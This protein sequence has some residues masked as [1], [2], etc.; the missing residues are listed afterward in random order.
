MN[1]QTIITL[2]TKRLKWTQEQL[3]GYLGIDRATVSRIEN[4]KLP[5]SGPVAKLLNQ[6][7]AEAPPA[8]ADS[9]AA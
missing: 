8:S 1:S 7:E 3:A 4:D 5:P 6:L 2:R 9:E